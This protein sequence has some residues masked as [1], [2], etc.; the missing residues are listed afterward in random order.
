MNAFEPS[1]L[2]RVRCG[3]SCAQ[4]DRNEPCYWLGSVSLSGS[5][6]K[7]NTAP[8]FRVCGCARCCYGGSAGFSP[9]NG[10]GSAPSASLLIF[11]RT[12]LDARHNFPFLELMHNIRADIATSSAGR[13]FQMLDQAMLG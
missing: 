8:P 12:H 9:A 13:R 4:L 3:A 10:F 2:A 1:D 7:T 11:L 5:E 6:W